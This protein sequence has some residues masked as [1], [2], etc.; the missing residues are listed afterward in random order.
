M[1]KLR[2]ATVSDLENIRIINEEAIPAVN[3]VSLEEFKWFL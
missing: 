2:E 1:F 3:A